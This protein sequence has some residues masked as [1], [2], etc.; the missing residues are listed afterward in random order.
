MPS[1]STSLID[2]DLGRDPAAAGAW[3]AGGALRRGATATADARVDTAVAPDLAPPQPVHFGPA[4]QPIAGWWHPVAGHTPLTVVI[5]APFGLEDLSAYRSLRYLAQLLNAA[6]LPTLRFDYAGCGDSAGD[7][8]EGDQL[9]AWLDSIDAA[10]DLARTLSGAQR[11][12]LV[13]VRLGALLAADAAARRTDVQS[14]AAIAPYASGRAF[15]RECRMLGAAA[16]VDGL[17]DDGGL[18]AGGFVLSGPTC[19]SLSKLALPKQGPSGFGSALVIDRDDMAP[20]P[21]SDQLAKLG[22]TVEQKVLPGFAAM[23]DSPHYAVTPQAIMAEV[24]AWLKNRKRETPA[25]TGSAPG[26]SPWV[27]GPVTLTLANGARVREQAI[28]ISASPVLT[29]QLIEP[30][31]PPRGPKRAVLILNTGSERRIG[32]NRLWVSFARERAALGDTVMRLDQAGVGESDLRPGSRENDVYGD[33][34]QD[35][36]R[37]AVDWLRNQAGATHCTLVGIC[38]GGFHSFQAA[39]GGLPIQSIVP[40]NP[41]LFYWH[42]NISL[43]DT[44]TTSGG[45]LV[46]MNNARRSLRDPKKWLGLLRGEVDVRGLLRV[47]VARNLRRGRLALRGLARALGRPLPKD[48]GVDLRNITRNGTAVHFLFAHGEPGLTLLHEETGRI[49]RH[50]QDDGLLRVS[51]IADA[52]HTFTAASSRTRL[53]GALHGALDGTTILNPAAKN[54]SSDRG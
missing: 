3:G 43:R 4:D 39:R 19:D 23:I 53:Y 51:M 22:V 36:V 31:T 18:Q 7:S 30:E 40:I 50:L 38:S 1:S 13:G 8:D 46:H 45:Q 28:R 54:E 35:D 49:G 27:N 20:S 6:G 10:I 41:M 15:V 48:L 5:C 32:P 26:A 17:R 21:W 42:P 37:A 34:V 25:T 14:L 24:V 16:G 11:V 33:A 29:A 2:P 47:I 44:A 9:P 52:D 12:A